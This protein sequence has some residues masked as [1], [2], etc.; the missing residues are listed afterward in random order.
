MVLPWGL[1]GR[2]ATK[3]QRQGQHD[4]GELR[5]E[6]GAKARDRGGLALGEKDAHELGAGL[7]R[8]RERLARRLVRGKDPGGGNESRRLEGALHGGERNALALDLDDAVRA[9]EKHEARGGEPYP[10]RAQV[11]ARNVEVT[12]TQHDD[13]FALVL[14]NLLVGV[15][16]GRRVGANGRLDP[17]DGRPLRREELVRSVLAEPARAPG[18]AARFGR[19]E[20]L[21][22]EAPQGGLRGAGPGLVQRARRR[23]DEG[24]VRAGLLEDLGRREAA[25]VRGRGDDR[26]AA[27]PGGALK[28]RLG[29]EFGKVDARPDEDGVFR[30]E[31]PEDPEE[32]PVDVLRAH[33]A[34]DVDGAER[35]GSARNSGVDR[36]GLPEDLLE[37]LDDELGA[38]G[39]AAREQREEL[40]PVVELGKVSRDRSGVECGEV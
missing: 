36:L 40:R 9:A 29:E 15:V 26:D 24:D 12:T 21:R 34:D 11:P 13:A 4:R 20:D 32:Q 8:R 14:K 30:E 2:L 38:S 22:G 16:A 3:R 17:L 35:P 39:A 28:D 18:D 25:Q 6:R 1:A 31:R 37:A 27:P 10:V 19:A 7:E 23:E 5:G 33:R